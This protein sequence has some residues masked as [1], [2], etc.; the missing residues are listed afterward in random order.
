MDERHSRSLSQL[1]NLN[2]AKK[3][4]NSSDLCE[5]N[6]PKAANEAFNLS[7]IAKQIQ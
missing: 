5:E 4:R 7:H 1:S 3:K 2:G 6:S